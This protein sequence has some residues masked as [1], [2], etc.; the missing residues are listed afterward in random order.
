MK[1]TFEDY[2]NQ[3]KQSMAEFKEQDVK[4]LEDHR[5]AKLAAH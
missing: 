2:A 1:P 3:L 5:Q 4:A